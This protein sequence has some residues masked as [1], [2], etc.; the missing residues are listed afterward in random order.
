MA[1]DLGYRAYM[2]PL[3]TYLKEVRAVHASGVL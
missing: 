1:S 2:N 3:E